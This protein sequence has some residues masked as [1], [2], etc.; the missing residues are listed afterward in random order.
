MKD[1]SDSHTI[2]APRLF[3]GLAEAQERYDAILCDI[4]GVL[5]NGVAAYPAAVDALRHLRRLGKAVTLITNAPRPKGEVAAQ[6]ASLGVPADAYDYIA[7]SGDV[8]A[9]EIAGR[10]PQRPYHIGAERDLPLFVTASELAKREIVPAPLTD[11]DF[12]V[13]TGLAD[14]TIETP[15]DYEEVLVACRAKNLVMIC[16]NPDLVVQRGDTTIFCAGALAERYEALGGAVEQAG[17]P[18]AAIYRLA[19]GHAEQALGRPL[20][21]ARV[22]AIGDALHTDIA[23]ACAMGLDSLFVGSGIHRAEVLDAS[24]AINIDAVERL[25]KEHGVAPNGLLSRLAW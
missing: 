11:A 13:C 23:G 20:D 21:L 2:E 22:L 19:I 18:F 25:A 12:I 5:H 16:A 15:A 3:S 7:T 8:C 9:H 14:D 4:W 6:L 17:K 10:A 1:I 24:G